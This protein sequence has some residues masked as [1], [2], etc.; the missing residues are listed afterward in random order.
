LDLT[1]AKAS[2]TARWFNPRTG[3]SLPKFD[4]A[5]ED[6]HSFTAPDLNDWA[7]ELKGNDR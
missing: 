6:E 2:L 1:A 5:R 7:L 3:E 4:W